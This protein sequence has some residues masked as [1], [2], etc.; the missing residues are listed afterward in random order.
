[1]MFRAILA[2]FSLPALVA[3]LFPWLLSRLT[4]PQV[5]PTNYGLILVVVGGSILLISV[6]SFYRRGRGTLAPWDPPKHLVVQDLYRFNRNPMYVGVNLVTL[7]WALSTGNPWNYAYAVLVSVM[8]HLR[9]VLYEEKKMQQLFGRQW[10]IYREHVPRWG[11][12]LRPYTSGVDALST[13]P[14]AT[15]RTGSDAG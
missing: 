14:E 13:A 15:R 11:V 9:V 10:E 5:A 4:G 6:V 1:M 2:F 8:F 7:G 3:G 12:R